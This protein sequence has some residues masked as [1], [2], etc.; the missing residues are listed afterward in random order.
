MSVRDKMQQLLIVIIGF[1]PK[2]ILVRHGHS[3][4]VLGYYQSFISACHAETQARSA[5]FRLKSRSS[6]LYATCYTGVRHMLYTCLAYA[7]HV[8]DICRT[9]V[10][11]MPD[12]YDVKHIQPEQMQLKLVIVMSRWMEGVKYKLTTYLA[13]RQF[14]II[15]N[16]FRTGLN[17]KDGR[18]AIKKIATAPTTGWHNNGFLSPTGIRP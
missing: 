5:C 12:T 9:R 14:D 18:W 2:Q 10:W 17:E 16:A 15:C 4:P 11:H 13:L 7:V 3:M 6:L 8:S 1:N